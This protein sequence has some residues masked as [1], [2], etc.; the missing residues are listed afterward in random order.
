[1]NTP[2]QDL[3]F[4]LDLALDKSL[5]ARKTL[6]AMIG[7]LFTEQVTKLTEPSGEINASCQMWGSEAPPCGGRR[8]ARSLP[9]SGASQYGFPRAPPHRR[10]VSRSGPS[11]S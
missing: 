10:P 9:V 6:T 1:M 4:L 7:D 3:H 8:G 2:D 5:D 11:A